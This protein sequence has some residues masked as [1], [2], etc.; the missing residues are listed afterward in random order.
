MPPSCPVLQDVT[1]INYTLEWPQLEKPSN[2]TFAGTPQIDICRCG[3]LNKHDV[4]HVYE[5][6]RCSRPEIRFSTPDEELWVLQAPLGQVNLLRPANNDEIQ[7]RREIHATAE[8]SA[9]KG[10]NILLLSGPCPRGRYQALAT[11]QYLKSLPPLARQ[12][13]NSLSLLI[14]PYEEDCSPSACGRA[15]L[16]LTHYIIEALPNFRTLCLNIWGE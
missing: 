10:K 12:N 7:R 1:T 15:Y 6:Y 14:Q 4:G 13:I 2:T 16:D 8:P 5:R 3:S 9:Y 11:L